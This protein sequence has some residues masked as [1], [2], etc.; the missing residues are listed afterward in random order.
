MGLP[1]R[2]LFFAL[3]SDPSTIR[4]MLVLLEKKGLVVRN[5][6]IRDGRALSVTLTHKGRRAYSQMWKDT[7]SVRQRLLAVLE[8]KETVLLVEL[9]G[10]IADAMISPTVPKSVHSKNH[11]S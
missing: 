7:Q 9:F 5:Q 8:P 1:N 4:A 11:Q 6:H 2:I 10:R 3:P